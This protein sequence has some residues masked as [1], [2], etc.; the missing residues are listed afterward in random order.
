MDRPQFVKLGAMHV[1]PSHIVAVVN[2]LGGPVLI[3]VGAQPIKMQGFSIEQ[4][5]DALQGK[6]PPSAPKIA[7]L[8]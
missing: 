3:V 7:G 6:T 1:N 2:D 8:N 4:V 5:L